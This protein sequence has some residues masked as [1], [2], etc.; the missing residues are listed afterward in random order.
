MDSL[1]EVDAFL[2][3][4]SCSVHGI[5]V[6]LVL[7]HLH[8]FAALA[9]LMTVFADHVQLADP[10]LDE[11]HKRS[12]KQTNKAK[13]VTRRVDCVWRDSVILDTRGSL[14]PKRLSQRCNFGSES[15]GKKEPL[16]FEERSRQT[17]GGG[18]GV[19]LAGLSLSLHD[20]RRQTDRQR[21]DVSGKTEA[22]GL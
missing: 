16:G 7:D 1:V 22:A 15:P 21:Q 9:L 17:D 4:L 19:K 5:L 8:P 18:G 3:E 11:G 12:N 10:V 13:A 6:R 14:S 2:S 20:T